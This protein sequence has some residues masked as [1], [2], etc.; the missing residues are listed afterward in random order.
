MMCCSKE[1]TNFFIHK[2]Q[3]P[4]KIL[5]LS[6]FL[7]IPFIILVSTNA[8]ILCF[9]SSIFKTRITFFSIFLRV[10]LDEKN[11]KED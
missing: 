11:E 5:I 6:I 9:V 7:L 3:I 1:M 10:N 2:Y 8:K 4:L